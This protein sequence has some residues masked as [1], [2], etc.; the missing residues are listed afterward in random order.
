LYA[1][2]QVSAGYA[3]EA[4][5]PWQREFEEAFLFEETPDQ[6]TALAEIKKDM[7][8]ET[9]MDRLLCGD[10]G[11]GK[12][13]VAIRA[14]FIGGGGRQ[15]GG[16][17]GATTVLAQQHY[18]TFSARFAGFGPVVEVISRFAA[19]GSSARWRPARPRGGW[20]C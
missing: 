8:S 2:R 1:E 17:A 5:T 13:E 20:M 12:T 15:A 11:F 19:R 6:L 7:E 18:Q 10:V 14:A 3:F 4:D 16:G 9:P